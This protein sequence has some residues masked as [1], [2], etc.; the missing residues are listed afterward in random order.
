M[1]KELDEFKK[2]DG[3]K[4]KS[5]TIRTAEPLENEAKKIFER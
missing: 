5:A 1:E 4:I 2:T 3:G